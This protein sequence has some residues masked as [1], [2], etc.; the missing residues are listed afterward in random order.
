M[1]LYNEELIICTLCQIALE[2]SL[3]SRWDGGR[4][5]ARMGGRRFRQYSSPKSE[6]KTS[7]PSRYSRTLENSIRMVL[8]SFIKERGNWPT[9]FN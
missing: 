1:K 4:N 7:L 6:G 2:L 3:Q 8:E 5:V 9:F